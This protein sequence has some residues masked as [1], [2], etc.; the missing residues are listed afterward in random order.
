MA[1]KKP[2]NDD[3]K[4][5]AKGVTPRVVVAELERAEEAKAYRSGLT[6][7]SQKMQSRLRDEKS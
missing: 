6:F 7:A 5:K 2:Q 4:R 1:T 3:E